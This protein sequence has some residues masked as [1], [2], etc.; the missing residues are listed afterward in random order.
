VGFEGDKSHAIPNP[1]Q[2]ISPIPTG[3]EINQTKRDRDV[4][5]WRWDT[6]RLLL[7]KSICADLMNDTTMF[8]RKSIWKLKVPQK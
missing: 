6:S 8:H 2:Y 4:F 1:L 5:K 3:V 7:V